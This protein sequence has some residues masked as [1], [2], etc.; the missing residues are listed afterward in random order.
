MVLDSAAS[1]KAARQPLVHQVTGT[2]QEVSFDGN[3]GDRRAGRVTGPNVGSHL[4][5]RSRR[6]GNGMQILGGVALDS[7]SN[8]RRPDVEPLRCR[9]DLPVV[10][11]VVHLHPHRDTILGFGQVPDV[12]ACLP[13]SIQRDI[14]GTG[15]V[16]GRLFPIPEVLVVPAVERRPHRYGQIR[17]AASGQVLNV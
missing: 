16:A 10:V 12:Q 14:G 1:T 17:G 6:Y 4:R 3:A 7:K 9:P 13:G 8:R 2:H 5:R 15:F 11:P